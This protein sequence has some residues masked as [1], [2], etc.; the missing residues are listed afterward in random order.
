MK[1]YT[2]LSESGPALSRALSL[3]A[4]CFY[5]PG[6]ELSENVRALYE[7]V[8]PLGSEAVAQA[9]RMLNELQ[10]QSREEL[11]KEYSRLFLGPFQLEAPPFGSVYL[12]D[13][14]RMMGES[15]TEAQRIYRECGLDM[16]PD[17]TSPPDHVAAELEFLA[18]LGFQESNSRDADQETFFREQRAWFLDRHIGRWFPMFAENVE[19]N[20]EM[21]FYLELTRL[22]WRLLESERRQVTSEPV[23]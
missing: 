19:N 10:Y 22:T 8:R 23:E 12:E 18:Y 5:Q 14:G 2:C 13:E 3:V 20:T 1:E 6:P 7:A 17:F 16:S 21:G 9:G 4:G 11:L 15:T